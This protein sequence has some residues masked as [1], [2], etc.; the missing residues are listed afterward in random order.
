MPMEKVETI[1]LVSCVGAKGAT[2]AP[3]RE[4]YQSD[5]FKKARI[6][7]ESIGS[8]WFIL[9]AKYGLVQPDETIKPYDKTLN[10]MGV[11]ER[12]DWSRHVQQQMDKWLPDADRI[13]VLAGERYRKFLMDY[14]GRRAATV[15]VP[16]AGMRIGEQ[17]S[18]L[19]RHTDDGTAR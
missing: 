15:D 8:C 4:L 14:L 16:M 10:T 1:C 3:A 18:W 5:W 6:Y 19:G 9:S 17:L 2:P 11:S 13:V 12:R 7:A